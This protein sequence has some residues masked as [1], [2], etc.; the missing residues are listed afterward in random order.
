[1]HG[2]RGRLLS[3]DIK[4]LFTNIPVDECIEVIR[5]HTTG[6]NPVFKDLPINADRF[7]E[8]L[9]LC[10]SFNQFSFGDQHYRQIS[11][12]PMGSSLSPVMSNIYM[13]HF[14]ANLMEEMIPVNMRPLLWMRF[15]DDIFC[16]YE[17]M[18]MFGTIDTVHV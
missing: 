10:T 18:T 17:D 7:C 15:V 16:C 2:S 9:K 14:E 6:P 8:L 13:E 4:S 1:M 3:L 11:G 5:T 12:L